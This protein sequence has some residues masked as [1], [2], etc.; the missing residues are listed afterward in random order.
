MTI[1]IKEQYQKQVEQAVN[2]F[3]R[4][5]DKIKTSENPYYHDEAV[6]DYEIQRLREE[7]E[8]QVNEINKQFNAE[9]DAKI[10]ELEPIAAKSYFRPTETDKRLV[11]EFVSEFLADAKLAFS[12]SEKLDAFEK[13]EEKLGFLDE[14]GLSLVRKRL[15]ELFDAL[16]DDTTLQSKIRGLNATLKELQ[17][18][19]KM[20]LEELIEQKMNGV[21]AAFR[22]LRLIHPA[23]SDYKYNRYNNA[24]R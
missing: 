23:F 12:E 10:E 22:R 3:R 15:P 5:F 11:D 4:D 16:S 8:K 19:E 17:T 1:N 13:F 24:N 2:K 14:N 7:L 18:T 9:I 6:R 21:D 20:A